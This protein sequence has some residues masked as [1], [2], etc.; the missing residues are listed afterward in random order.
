MKDL[1][2]RDVQGTIESTYVSLRK[3]GIGSEV[4]HTPNK[5]MW[6]VLLR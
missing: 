3:Q 4:K 6:T 5:K 1:S 2:L